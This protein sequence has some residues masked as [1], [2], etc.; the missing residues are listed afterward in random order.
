MDQALVEILQLV[1]AAAGGVV[2]K[3]AVDRLRRRPAPPL[4][5]AP[6][7][8]QPPAAAP[9]PTVSPFD[10]SVP[11]A[12]H[13]HGHELATPPAPPAPDPTPRT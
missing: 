7:L 5:P 4:A 1:S 10:A 11:W 3:G 13:P 12:F 2:L 9:R 6:A 8:V